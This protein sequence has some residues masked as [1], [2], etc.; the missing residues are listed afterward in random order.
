VR[1]YR[2]K[3]RRMADRALA[4][5]DT[6]PEALIWWDGYRQAL[7]D[8]ENPPAHAEHPGDYDAVIKV[9]ANLWRDEGTTRREAAGR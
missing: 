1:V 3:L 2:E 7:S 8:L 9:Q 6:H 4:D 5:P